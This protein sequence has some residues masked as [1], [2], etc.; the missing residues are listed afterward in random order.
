MRALLPFELVIERKVVVGRAQ[1][2]LLEGGVNI[3]VIIV[4]GAQAP[5]SLLASRAFKGPI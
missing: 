4:G 1:R 3:V 5:I 2:L